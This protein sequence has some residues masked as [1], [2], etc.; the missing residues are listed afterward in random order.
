[1]H[2]SAVRMANSATLRT[3]EKNVTAPSSSKRAVRRTFVLLLVL[4]LSVPT[5]LMPARAA[6]LQAAEAPAPAPVRVEGYLKFI[7]AGSWLVGAH[8]ILVDARTAVFEKRGRAEVGAWIIVWGMQEED[9]SIHAELIQVDRPAGG[10]GPTVQTAGMLRKMSTD[11]WIIEQTPVLITGTTMISGNPAIGV[12]LWVVAE[13]QNDLLVAIAVEVLA[14]RAGAPPV[15]FEG[16]IEA[17]G[18]ELWQVDGHPVRLTPET[19]LIGEPAPD[20]NAEVRAVTGTDGDLV[21]DLIRVVDPRS[22]AR[23]NAVVTA[24]ATEPDGAQTWTVLAF[25]EQP[26]ADPAVT[27]L[28]ID[29]RTLIDE[30]RAVARTGQWV[31]VIGLAVGSREYQAD[32][33]RLEQPVPV[34]L[35]G[36]LA[37]APAAAAD[38]GWWQ[39]DDRPVWWAG[40]GPARAANE[41]AP[42]DAVVLGVRLPNGI[43]WA[44]DVSAAKAGAGAKL[45][46]TTPR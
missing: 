20:K 25:P 44:Q 27:T 26:W 24:M 37:A 10:T 15:E 40:S 4:A 29:S 17:F 8:S 41:F 45:P 21:A 18:P 32:V 38:A 34:S 7:G 28:H 31:E 2:Y 5:C 39:V 3:G 42:N 43:I 13:Q 16:K 46:A 19:V 11:L 6:R 30:G 35:R 23:L 12:L 33:I 36:K 22:E 14:P 9:G 1:M